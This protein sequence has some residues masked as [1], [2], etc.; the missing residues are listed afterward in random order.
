MRL[1]AWLQSPGVQLDV[2]AGIVDGILTAL[3]ITAAKI[4]GG[5]GGGA[6]GVDLSLAM[7]VSLAAG[8]TTI[9]AF[10]L[11]HYAQLRSGLNRAEHQLNVLRH[12]RLATSDLG[13]K[14]LQEALEGATV[15]AMCSVLG[16][17]VPLIVGILLPAPPWLGCAVSIAILGALGG[18][19]AR[20]FEGSIAIWTAALAL[21]GVTFTGIGVALRI[22]G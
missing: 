7:R 6:G 21:A 11:A 13:R 20:S 19:L 18:L 10:F 14:V 8:L 2:V 12:G 22:A 17:F 3:T 5:D 16:A 15:A 9:V 1:R 4:L